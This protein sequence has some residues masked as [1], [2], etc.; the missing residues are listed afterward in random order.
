MPTS[1]QHPH[2]F[3]SISSQQCSFHFIVSELSN[4]ALMPLSNTKPL[5]KETRVLL[6]VVPNEW[7][8]DSSGDICHFHFCV[9]VSQANWRIVQSSWDLL[10]N[11]I[12]LSTVNSKYIYFSNVLKISFWKSVNNFKTSANERCFDLKF[13]HL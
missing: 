4:N 11:L 10:T 8:S 5:F 3:L 2:S 9:I 6:E 12:S 7:V 13:V 1:H